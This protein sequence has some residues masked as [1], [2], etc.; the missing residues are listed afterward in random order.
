[1]PRI[2]EKML[3]FES[4]VLSLQINMPETMD[5]STMYT[6]INAAVE[7]MKRGGVILYPTD[8]VWGI[9][10]DAT[11]SEA[12]RRVFE[13]K[14]RAEAKAMISLVGSV[15]ML[16]RYVRDIP[17][18]AYD[19]VDL[20]VSP[21][22]VIYDSPCGI[23]PELIAEDGSAAFRV[24]S[25]IYSHG[26]CQ[27]LG[28]PVVSSSANV[29]GEHTPRFFNEIDSDLVGAVD[30]V[31]SYRRDDTEARKSSSIIKISSDCSIKIIRE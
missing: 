11:N 8:T 4:V 13:L 1:M 22:T 15:A 9:G 28:R 20:A 19:M 30:Y 21:L 3:F 10:C 31:A 23:A 2:L 17:D 18:V 26:L 29:S 6:D 12:V 25:E 7:C 14:R 5:K 16:E 24:T 27:G